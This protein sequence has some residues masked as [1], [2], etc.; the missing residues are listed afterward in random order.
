ML[1]STFSTTFILTLFL[2]AHL[3]I[4]F[5]ILD[6]FVGCI[7]TTLEKEN[8]L[9]LNNKYSISLRLIFIQMVRVMPWKEDIQINGIC[10]KPNYRLS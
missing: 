10:T 5:L 1:E 2:S 9:G 4:S 6:P 3:C 8:I 7:N